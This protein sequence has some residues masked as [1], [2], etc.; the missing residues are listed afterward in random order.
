MTD[1]DDLNGWKLRTPSEMTN[2]CCS[3]AHR[4]TMHATPSFKFMLVGHTVHL[5][6]TDTQIRMPGV[7]Y[8]LKKARRR[9]GP[10]ATMF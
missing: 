1:C 9:A 5:P 4:I 10:K 8:M 7:S 6:D 2:L 3:P